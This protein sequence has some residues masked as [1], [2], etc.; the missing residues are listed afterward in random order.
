MA[1]P[2]PRVLPLATECVARSRTKPTRAVR[3]QPHAADE[4]TAASPPSPLAVGLGNRRCRTESVRFFVVRLAVS[5]SP[6]GRPGAW[7]TQPECSP[8][9]VNPRDGGPRPSPYRSL[10][11]DATARHGSASSERP[12]CW[13]QPCWSCRVRPGR[14]PA[15]PEA[16][17]SFRSGASCS[18]V[19]FI[20]MRGPSSWDGSIKIWTRRTSAPIQSRTPTG[21][22]PCRT[23]PS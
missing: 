4:A 13:P 3:C 7:E 20:G 16:R 22:G 11:W 5:G 12:S 17:R 8:Y 14:V 23:P 6:A 9:R 10:P 19:T 1:L 2:P 21:D 18:R 15:E